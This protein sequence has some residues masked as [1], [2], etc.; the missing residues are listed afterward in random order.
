MNR[1]IRCSLACLPLVVMALPLAATPVT[2][3]AELDQQTALN[4]ALDQ[5]VVAM[6]EPGEPDPNWS[7]GGADVEKAIRARPGHVALEVDKD[8]D[9]AIW[10]FADRPASTYIPQGWELVTEIGQIDSP[11]NAGLPLEIGQAEDGYY[12]VS[13]SNY[14]RVGDAYCSSAP[15]TAR[16]YKAKGSADGQMSPK[17][18]DLI[19][20]GMLERA[21]SKTVCERYDESGGQYLTRYYLKDGRSL[22]FFNEM[23]GTVS[24]EPQRPTE[25]MLLGE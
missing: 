15:V 6:F 24:L 8:G 19:Y 3:S 20:R 12:S 1:S 5:A 11:E 2:G 13:R 18:I 22:P 9:R 14:E 7:K 4:Q 21:K 23:S 17:V 10:F 25:E 16:L